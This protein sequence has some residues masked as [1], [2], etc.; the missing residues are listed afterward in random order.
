[1]D[2]DAF[3]IVQGNLLADNEKNVY[4][5]SKASAPIL[6]EMYYNSTIDAYNSYKRDPTASNVTT[7]GQNP[8]CLPKSSVCSFQRKGSTTITYK[9]CLN[10]A[11]ECKKIF[12]EQRTNQATI[13]KR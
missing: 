8:N 1:M 9:A 5:K 3:F 2:F 4:F 10:E 6:H 7:N 12:G 13:L 11:W